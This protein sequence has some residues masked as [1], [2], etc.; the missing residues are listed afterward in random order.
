MI[1]PIDRRGPLALAGTAIPTPALADVVPSA[2]ALSQRSSPAVGKR[3]LEIPGDNAVFGASGF[4][5]EKYGYSPAVRAGGLLFMA[6]VVGARSDGAV[7]ESVAEQAELAFQRTTE[8]LRLEGLT[9]A[10]LA[11]SSC[12][13][14]V[15]RA[16]LF[17]LIDHRSRGPG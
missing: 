5:F 17:G 13:R 11:I 10:D 3:V 12:Q 4:A 9:T 8:I 16:P 7:P 2:G 14:A 15:Y 6:G 1:N